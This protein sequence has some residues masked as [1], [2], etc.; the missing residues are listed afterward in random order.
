MTTQLEI[1]W[2][3]HRNSD[4]MGLPPNIDWTA[5]AARA[6][7][8]DITAGKHGGNPESVAAYR[9]ARDSMPESRAEVLAKIKASGRRGL[10]CKECAEV[11]GVE[12]HAISGRITELKAA[13]LIL[14]NGERRDGGAALVA[15]GDT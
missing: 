12:M 9:R 7:G 15:N 4:D 14:P 5:K 6:V 13:G 1:D 10:T 11:M 3:L 2:P 8:R